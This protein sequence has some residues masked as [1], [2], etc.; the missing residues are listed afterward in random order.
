MTLNEIIKIIDGKTIINS[1]LEIN[2]IKT[3]SRKIKKGDIFIALNGKSYDGNKYIN[4]ALK[5]GAIA[6]ITT[7][8]INDKCIEVSDTYNSLFDIAYYLRSK[9]NIPLI[10]ITGSNGKTTTKDLVCHIL[11][12]KYNVLKNEQNKNN[13]IGVSET[14]FKLNKNHEIIVMELGSNHMGEISYLSKMCKPDISL[15]TNIGSSHLGYFKSRK[16]I[17]KEKSSILDGMNNKKLIVNGDDKYL[18]KLD[19]FKCGLNSRTDLM[20]Y[21]IY[22]D[23]DHISFN[24]YLDKEY[25]VIFNNPGKHFIPDILL[26]IKVSL[27]YGVKIKTI[28]KRIRTFKQTDKRMNLINSGSNTIINDCY[29]ASYESV[30]GGLDYLNSIVGNKVLILGDILE[31]GKYSKKIHKKINKKLKYVNK[32]LVLTVG[33]YSKYIKGIHFSNNSEL[34]EYLKQNSIRN[35]YIYVKGSRRMNLDEIV[36]YLKM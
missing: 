28:L 2:E 16:N 30:I 18:K 11:S 1:E 17:F 12:S 9:Y 34:I 31:L 25:Q 33:E 13:L 35:S 20:A 4:E 24:I 10:G 21:N 22:Q 32:D 5:K 6:C 14:L 15:I 8:S 36:E 7:N 29:N 3:D 27:E 19:S 23:I 26:A